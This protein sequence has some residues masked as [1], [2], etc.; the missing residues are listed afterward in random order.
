MKRKPSS[1]FADETLQTLVYISLNAKA[2][3]L[4]SEPQVLSNVILTRRVTKSMEIVNLL[5]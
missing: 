5:N 3:H 1:P 2:V 4:H